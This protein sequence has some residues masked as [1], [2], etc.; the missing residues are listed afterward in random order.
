MVLRLSTV[1]G[2]SYAY[3]TTTC[4]LQH[5]FVLRVFLRTPSPE[6]HVCC[7]LIVAHP[8]PFA[9]NSF[10]LDPFLPMVIFPRTGA[11]LRHRRTYRFLAA[12]TLLPHPPCT[13]AAAYH[14]SS[15]T[16]FTERSGGTI[17]VSPRNE[18]EQSG[19]VVICHGLGDTA[20]GFSDVAEVSDV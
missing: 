4:S 18:A 14:F 10:T 12:F 5:S 1:Q 3:I 6:Y 7:R 13:A 17:T 9:Q 11:S 15:M 16:S 20:E 19:L 8:L 2:T